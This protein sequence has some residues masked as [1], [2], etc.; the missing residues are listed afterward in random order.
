VVRKGAGGENIKGE[1]HIE[2]NPAKSC[3]CLAKALKLSVQSFHNNRNKIEKESKL[4]TT[5]IHREKVPIEME[6][7]SYNNKKREEKRRE[8]KL[9]KDSIERAQRMDHLMRLCEVPQRGC[10]LNIPYERVL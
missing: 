9:A 7:L 5:H 10:Y 6:A 1:F 2:V 3:I 8:E 4:E